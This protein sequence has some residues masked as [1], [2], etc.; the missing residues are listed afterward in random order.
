MLEEKD[1][2]ASRFDFDFICKE[3]LELDNNELDELFQI[4]KKA[5]ID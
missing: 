5:S 1:L 4:Y 2:F 3:L